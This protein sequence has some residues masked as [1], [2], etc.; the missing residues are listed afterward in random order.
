MNTDVEYSHVQF[1]LWGLEISGSRPP[2]A[3]RLVGEWMAWEVQDGTAVS[4]VS[5]ASVSTP[6]RRRE[7][8][9]PLDVGNA[10]A[11]TWGDSLAA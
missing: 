4:R 5:R 6:A 1:G 9:Y 10:P 7:E 11:G 2:A 3:N 8:V